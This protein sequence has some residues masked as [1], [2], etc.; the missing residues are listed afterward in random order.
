MII[1]RQITTF[2]CT[3]CGYCWSS[4]FTI[5]GKE[6][7]LCPACGASGLDNITPNRVYYYPTNKNYFT[8]SVCDTC[9]NNPKNGGNGV[10]HCTLGLMTSTCSVG[11][12]LAD[13]NSSI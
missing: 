9:S 2:Q 8:P 1:K 11:R 4:A 12:N 5:N 13:N 7:E 10:C 6:P 3:C